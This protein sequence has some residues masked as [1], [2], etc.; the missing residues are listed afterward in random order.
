MILIVFICHLVVESGDDI[1][2]CMN[3]R[4]LVIANHQSTGDVPLLMA[5]FNARKGILPNIMWIMDKLFK[6]TNFGAVSIVHRDYF[7]TSVCLIIF[8]PSPLFIE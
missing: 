2:V 7:I 3:K 6:Y 1:E 4:T 5:A 8:Y